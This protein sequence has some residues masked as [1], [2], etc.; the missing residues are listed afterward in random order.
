VGVILNLAVWFAIHALF[1]VVTERRLGGA[2]VPVP[3]PASIDLF[4][5]A[6][7]AVAFAGMRRYRWGIIPV[8]L[9]SAAAGLVARA[10][11]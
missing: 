3:S 10:L 5:V 6:L 4:A 11:G 1:G 7:A 2:V 9:G 8:V